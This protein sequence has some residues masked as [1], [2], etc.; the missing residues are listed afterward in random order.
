MTHSCPASALV[1]FIQV[2]ITMK[3]R[4]CVCAAV[5]AG[6]F[7]GFLA[8]TD[9][10]EF[11]RL[12]A[13]AAAGSAVVKYYAEPVYRYTPYVMPLQGY[14]IP[15]PPLAT[16]EML[17]NRGDV[18]THRARAWRTARCVIPT[19]RRRVKRSSTYPVAPFGPSPEVQLGDLRR[20]R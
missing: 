15:P 16:Y 3:V 9:A 6:G 18:P 8:V 14:G 13:V 2:S 10:S 17:H 7:L 12:R 11:L 5:L 19:R 20:V 4:Q 1:S